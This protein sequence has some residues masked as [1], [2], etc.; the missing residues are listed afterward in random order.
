M[1]QAEG[2]KPPQGKKERKARRMFREYT[3]ENPHWRDKALL[4]RAK[5]AERPPIQVKKS[6]KVRGRLDEARRIGREYVEENPHWEEKAVLL[7]AK[8]AA[9]P[10]R[11]GER[12]AMLRVSVDHPE[13]ARSGFGHARVWQK[14][15][16]HTA[17]S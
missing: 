16:Q 8:S 4:L 11:L 12:S 1:L 2:K 5:S 17:Q 10:P 3:E 7:R 14:P 9:R 6:R 13:A 15:G